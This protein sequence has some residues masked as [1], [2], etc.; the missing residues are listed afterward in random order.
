MSTTIKTIYG[1]LDEKKLKDLKGAISEAT[2]VLHEIDQQ[3]KILKDII[4]IASDNSSIPKK[5]I[6]RIAKVQY[7]QNLAEEVAEFKEFEALVES[8]TEVK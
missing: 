5:I 2:N 3:K 8:I 1:V 6:T 7:K 4:D